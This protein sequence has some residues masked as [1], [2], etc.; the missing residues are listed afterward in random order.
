MR[1]I[2][3]HMHVLDSF[4]MNMRRADINDNNENDRIIRLIKQD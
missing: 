4:N 1:L 3:Y 2:E